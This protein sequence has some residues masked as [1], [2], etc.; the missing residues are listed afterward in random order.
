MD[1][2]RR[3]LLGRVANA[4]VH[5]IIAAFTLILVTPIFV[6]HSHPRHSLSSLSLTLILVTP[7]FVTHSHPRHSH[8]RHS[9]PSSSLTLILVT[10]SH[11]E[12]VLRILLL[13]TPLLTIRCLGPR[14]RV[15]F[16][17]SLSSTHAP[18]RELQ[19]VSSGRWR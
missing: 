11:P 2:L 12:P 19:P 18:A 14:R 6:T 10:D 16:Y 1:R 7:I 3:L 9:L 5:S 13:F 15:G 4:G 17:S 8:P